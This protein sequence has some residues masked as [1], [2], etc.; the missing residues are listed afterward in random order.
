MEHSDKRLKDEGW[1][2]FVKMVREDE[3]LTKQQM[4]TKQQTQAA[5]PEQQKNNSQSNRRSNT[6]NNTSIMCT[7]GQ[8][9]E[10]NLKAMIQLSTVEFEDDP[11]L[12]GS[13]VQQHQQQ[14]Q[15]SKH[16]N[17]RTNEQ[18]HKQAK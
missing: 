15:A 1:V 16:T 12:I 7:C 3:P 5:R 10:E 18:A 4:T 11:R 13:Q 9:G 8:E 17:K 6:R 14:Q 2:S